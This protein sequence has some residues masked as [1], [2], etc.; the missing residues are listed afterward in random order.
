MNFLQR[1]WQRWR[2]KTRA[3]VKRQQAKEQARATQAARRANEAGDRAKVLRP[4]KGYTPKAFKPPKGTTQ[5]PEPY[6]PPQQQ[7]IA[8]KQVAV[9]QPETPRPAPYDP[10]PAAS[11]SRVPQEARIPDP[12]PA[13]AEQRPT[14]PFGAPEASPTP[15]PRTAS[16]EID[17]G[18]VPSTSVPDARVPEPEVAEPP[19]R[20][21]TPEVTVGGNPPAPAPSPME[22]VWGADA[23]AAERQRQA[24]ETSPLAQPPPAG[25][26]FIP[27]MQNA[28]PPAAEPATQQQSSISLDPVVTAISELNENV[29][30]VLTKMDKVIE[31]LAEIASKGTTGSWT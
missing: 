10:P 15:T 19:Q 22:Q 17:W 12:E 23:K 27:P 14:V 26:P 3:A 4:Q 6:E 20:V 29:R 11:E 16:G 21:T 13:G 9:P 28:A 25:Q 2:R 18:R 5:S 24:A 7:A 8:P 30:E 31:V 1:W